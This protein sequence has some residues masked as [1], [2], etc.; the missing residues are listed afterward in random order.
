MYT[1][2][3]DIVYLQYLHTHVSYYREYTREL[4]KLICHFQGTVELSSYTG[5]N[6]R[7]NLEPAVISLCR[8]VM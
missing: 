2:L 8:H 7:Y 5:Q 1:Y 3:P 6:V 4:F